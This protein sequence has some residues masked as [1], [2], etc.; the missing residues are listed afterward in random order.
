MQDGPGSGG[1]RVP[2]CAKLQVLELSFPS[3]LDMGYVQ[4]GTT[5]ECSF[6]IKN[7]GQVDAPFHCDSPQPFTLTPGSGVV[8]VGSSIRIVCSVA[9]VGAAV[10]VSNACVRVGEG[11]NAIKPHPLLQIKLSC[12]AK[13]CH[14]SASQERVDFDKVLV[15][16][17]TTTSSSNSI[18]A[19]DLN[20]VK[21]VVLRNS[22]VVPAEFQVRVAITYDSLSCITIRLVSDVIVADS[23]LAACSTCH[24]VRS[25]VSV[26]IWML[27][28][29]V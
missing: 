25:H 27:S 7:T 18:S 15:N 26:L 4:V 19:A 14:I 29:S 1:F 28:A 8:P 24:T 23:H 5:S 16:T 11:C 20:P 10:Y 12:I 9:P 6:M 3:G 2:V 17:G 13:F 21:E 22:S